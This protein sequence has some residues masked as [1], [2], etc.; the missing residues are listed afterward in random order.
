M[1]AG[2]DE[3]MRAGGE[4][5]AAGLWPGGALRGDGARNNLCVI[6]SLARPGHS[7]IW[8]QTH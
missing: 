2:G 3:V 8:G 6:I 1:R 7:I 5:K 4:H